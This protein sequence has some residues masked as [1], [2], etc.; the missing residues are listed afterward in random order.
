M[1]V[2]VLVLALA[3]LS[4][5]A[6]APAPGD[7]C[8]EGAAVCQSKQKA[9]VCVGG[10]YQATGCRGPQGC[11]VTN[12]RAIM[13]DQSEGALVGELCLPGYRGQA[14]CATENPGSYLTC[15]PGGWSA[16][17]CPNGT[18]SRRGPDVVCE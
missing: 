2:N 18:C 16:V 12:D 17:A 14:Q 13:C 9:L 8:R 15:G 11:S 3:F 10:F 6:H 1:R 5:C 7:V 4:D